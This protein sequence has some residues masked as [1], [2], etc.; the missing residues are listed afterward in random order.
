MDSFEK[1]FF[2][3]KQYSTKW[4]KYFQVYDKIFSKYRGKEI[5]F[6]EIGVF[7]GGSLEIWK[8]YFGE[9]ARIIGIDLN[10]KC[11]K[12]ENLSKKIEIIVGNQSDPDFWD[13]FFFNLKGGVDIVLDDGGHTNLDQ[14][15]TSVKVLER[16][17]DN[18]TL[19]VEDTCTSY[20]EKYN[21]SKKY[22]FI[23]FAKK[24]IDDLNSN[25]DL[26]LDLNFKFSL[27]KHVY[28]IEI[29]ESMVV[30]NIDRKKTFINK[31]VSNSVTTSS[32]EDFTWYGNEINIIKEKNFLKKIPLLRLN[33]F[34]NFLK[35]IK[36]NSILK[37][38]F[39]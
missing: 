36:N 13:G 24:T 10:P 19:V 3:Q 6:V 15:I 8:R 4:K 18:G 17:N 29:F 20:V 34:I 30:F 26:E 9:K 35:K 12:F 31:R 2:S 38:F 25:I 22:S 39:E 5:I 21:S 37:K 1:I 33:K 7:E 27:K 32:I 23:N 16:I 11:K 28:S 14:I